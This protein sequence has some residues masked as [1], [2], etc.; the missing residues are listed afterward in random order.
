[1]DGLVLAFLL[2][3]MQFED[4]HYNDK[5]LF[6]SLPYFPHTYTMYLP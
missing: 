6:C 1:M 3:N 4:I 5:P 2:Y